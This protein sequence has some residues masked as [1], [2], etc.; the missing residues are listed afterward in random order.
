MDSWTTQTHTFHDILIQ[1]APGKNH[2]AKRKRHDLCGRCVDQSNRSSPPP[3]EADEE[4]A[5]PD[6]TKDPLPNCPNAPVAPIAPPPGFCC[7][8]CCPDPHIP[9]WAFSFSKSFIDLLAPVPPAAGL[10]PVDDPSDMDHKSSK[11]LLGFGF[12]A[13]LKD[14]AMVGA[15]AG[16]ELVRMGSEVGDMVV[17]RMGG[18]VA[19]PNTDV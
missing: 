10:L 18:E 6:P 7:C 9:A 2:C 5:A 17:G 13:P 19:P 3:A 4:V 16:V 8:D 12:A 1:D 15:I 14:A 11:L